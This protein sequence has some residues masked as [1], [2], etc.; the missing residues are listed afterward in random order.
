MGNT[1]GDLHTFMIACS[2]EGMA[3]AMAMAAKCRWGKRLGLCNNQMNPTQPNPT[4]KFRVAVKIHNQ[5]DPR[6]GLD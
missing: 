1:A 5:P 6:I 2:F 3:M 4:F